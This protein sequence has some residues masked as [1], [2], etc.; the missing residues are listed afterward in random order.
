MKASRNGTNLPY[1]TPP[2]RGSDTVYAIW[3]GTYDVGALAFFIDSQIPG[4]TLTD[5]TDCI[6]EALDG[7]YSAGGRYFVLMNLVPLDLVPLYSN[8]TVMGV[9]SSKYWPESLA[10]KRRFL[11]R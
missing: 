6:F 8:D 9:D 3:I 7:L 11:K 1:F 2:L 4:R 5:Y 10:T